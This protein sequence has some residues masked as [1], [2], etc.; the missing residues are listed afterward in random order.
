MTRWVVYRV[1]Y[2]SWRHLTIE[3]YLSEFAFRADALA[4]ARDHLGEDVTV[5]EVRS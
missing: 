1:E 3:T 2:D 4:F 5:R